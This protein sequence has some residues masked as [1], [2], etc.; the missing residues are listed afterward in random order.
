MAQT[1]EIIPT[2]TIEEMQAI[3]KRTL[4]YHRHLREHNVDPFERTRML[5]FLGD[6]GAGKTYGI[7][8][9]LAQMDAAN[10]MTR[11]GNYSLVD[12]IG[13][14]SIETHATSGLGMTHFNPPAM[15]HEAHKGTSSLEAWLH[16]EVTEMTDSTQNLLCGIVYDSVLNDLPL[17]PYILHI[18]TGNFVENKAGSREQISK[19][20]NRQRQYRIVRDGDGFIKHLMGQEDIDKDTVAFLHWK[21]EDAIYGK[22]GFDP[23]SSINNTPRQWSAVA[24]LPAPDF[25]DRM[26]VHAYSMDASSLVRKGDVAEL[27]AFRKLIND[28]AFV[29]IE[30]IIKTPE[31]APVP[32]KI[33]VCYALGSRLLQNIKETKHFEHS[34]K[35]ISRLRAEPQTWFVNSCVKILPEIQGTRAYIN[36]AKNNKVYFT[37]RA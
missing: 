31:S 19:L 1:H 32:D 3:I 9:V 26:D 2:V 23:K 25:T 15:G 4:G 33:D 13:V 18:G 37:G 29:P 14:P 11:D 6:P 5:M 7:N 12:F 34:M 28:P 30:Q 36:W 24:R 8:D 20:K 17:D 27:I 16:D 35:Y 10:Q 21:G 22:E